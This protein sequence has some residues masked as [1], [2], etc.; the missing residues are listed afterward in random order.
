MAEHGRRLLSEMTNIENTEQNHTFKIYPVPA[1]DILTI[2]IPSNNN[3]RIEIYDSKG[4][5]INQ[6]KIQG[7]RQNINI[8]ILSKG[9]YL[10]KL[11]DDNS[12]SFQKLVKN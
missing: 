8:Q 10:I 3:A 5:L 9:I 1:K 7:S 11:I 4:Q 12:V 2:E 6:S